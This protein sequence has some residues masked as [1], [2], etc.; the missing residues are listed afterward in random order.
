MNEDKFWGYILNEEQG[1]FQYGRE[2]VRDGTYES[3][4]KLPYHQFPLF[5]SS[6]GSGQKTA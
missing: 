1:E 2:V 6:V 4:L 3:Q 5:S